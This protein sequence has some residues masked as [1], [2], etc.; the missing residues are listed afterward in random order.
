MGAQAVV[1]GVRPP[2]PPRSDGTVYH[3][4]CQDTRVR[5]FTEASS[6]HDGYGELLTGSLRWLLHVLAVAQPSKSSNVTYSL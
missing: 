5:G 1:R 4:Y 6:D 3:Q 2:L